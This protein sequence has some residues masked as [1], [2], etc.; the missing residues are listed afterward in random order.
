M[1][2]TLGSA[3]LARHNK[4]LLRF[5]ALA[6]SLIA[7]NRAMTTAGRVVKRPMVRSA[8]KNERLP[9]WMTLS[10]A[11]LLCILTYGLF[12]PKKPSAFDSPEAQTS[13]SFHR[14]WDAIRPH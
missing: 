7:R 8:N 6:R 2:L 10:V 5:E 4:L 9:L 14:P 3:K 11:F 13:D 1:P 12:Q